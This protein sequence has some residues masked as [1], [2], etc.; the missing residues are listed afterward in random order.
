MGELLLPEGCTKGSTGCMPAGPSYTGRLL[1]RRKEG[2][3]QQ[4]QQQENARR[5]HHIR[6]TRAGHTV[7]REIQR[8]RDGQTSNFSLSLFSLFLLLPLYRT[9]AYVQ[10]KAAT[11]SATST[12]Y[13]DDEPYTHF[14]SSNPWSIMSYTYVPYACTHIQPP[15][16]L[17][18][19]RVYTQQT[20]LW[21]RT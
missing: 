7:Y 10:S 14:I 18:L 15:M 6:N 16:N 4:A 17:C 20:K 8:S 21:A 3:L 1:R 2:R 9:I 5:W 12:M 11:E 19:Y 13:H